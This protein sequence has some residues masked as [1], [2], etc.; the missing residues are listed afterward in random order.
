MTSVLMSMLMS[1]SAL[2][3][4]AGSFD[5]AVDCTV[6]TAI[7]AATTTA[8]EQASYQGANAYWAAAIF[9][10]GT[11]AGMAAE[12][13]GPYVEQAYQNRG[14]QYSTDPDGIRAIADVCVA[15]AG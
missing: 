2:A 14:S 7:M 12:A 3:S 1:T 4:Q 15:Q 10:A 9:E 6:T 8:A 11:S 13:V 5:Q